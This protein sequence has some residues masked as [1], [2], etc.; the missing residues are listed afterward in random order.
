MQW[1][2]RFATEG[3]MLPAFMMAFGSLVVLRA[4][5]TLQLTKDQ[6]DE[7]PSWMRWIA[8]IDSAR[9]QRRCGWAIIAFALV[10]VIMRVSVQ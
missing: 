5:S 2:Q 4:S 6:I 1:F 7:A 8:T 10:A 3:L 9:L